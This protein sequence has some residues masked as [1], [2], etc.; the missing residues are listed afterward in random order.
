MSEE[1]KLVGTTHTLPGSR[2]RVDL[3]EVITSVD[4]EAVDEGNADDVRV[5]AVMGLK[6]I[7]GS[8]CWLATA[9]SLFEEGW[10]AAGQI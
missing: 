9:T 4:D 10:L 8:H 6:T 3:I 7:D 1:V 2:R 5:A